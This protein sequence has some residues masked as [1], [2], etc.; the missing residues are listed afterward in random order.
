MFFLV[1]CFDFLRLSG[2]FVYSKTKVI[3]LGKALSLI[4]EPQN[5]RKNLIQVTQ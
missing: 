1:Y 4:I 3:F 5:F 2:Y